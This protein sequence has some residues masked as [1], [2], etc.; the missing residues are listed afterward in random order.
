MAADGNTDAGICVLGMLAGAGLAHT[1]NLAASG[2]GVPV[3][4]QTAVIIGIVLTFVIGWLFREK[5][6]AQSAA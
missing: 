1:I 4:G 3:N 2:A 5:A 6:L